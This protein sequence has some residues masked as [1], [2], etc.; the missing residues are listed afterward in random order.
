M[1]NI[2][3]L[4][5]VTAPSGV[6]VLGMAGWIDYWPQLGE[7]LAKRASAAA[8][9]GGGHLHDWFC[10]AVA[11]PASPNKRLLVHVRTN[12]S[13]YDVLTIGTLEVE[14][15]RPWP[16]E[17]TDEPIHLADL[18]VDRCGTVLG[19]ATA[20]ENFVGINGST[21]DGLADVTYMG[22]SAE[23][24]YAHFGGEHVPSPS[25]SPGRVR[26]WLDLPL[27]E[28]RQRAAALKAWS[29]DLGGGTG[30][31]ASVA[32]HTHHELL[33]R[34]G[35][36]HPLLA[37]VIDVAGCQ[38]LGFN[39]DAIDHSMRHRGERRDGQVYPVTLEPDREGLTRLRWAIPPQAGPIQVC[40]VAGLAAC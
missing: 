26:G 36:S 13:Y 18:P 2:V 27:E 1:D 23:D 29:R 32:E 7:P 31:V 10:E 25:P 22:R 14:L 8:A 6:L 28:A 24:A 11:V 39:W 30:L 34:A 3:E 38:V 15:G 33:S 19:D 35:W 9:N 17:H 40:R 21:I 37:A 4:G 5:F 20:L 16:N 12:K